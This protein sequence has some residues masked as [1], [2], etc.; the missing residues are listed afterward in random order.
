MQERVAKRVGGEL[1]TAPGSG[2]DIPLDGHRDAAA[3]FVL[4]WLE[5]KAP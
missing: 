3:E 5:E 1:A 2:H 4:L